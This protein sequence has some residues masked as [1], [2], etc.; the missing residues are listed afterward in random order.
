MCHLGIN[1]IID[2]SGKLLYIETKQFNEN[3]ITPSSPDGNTI[4]N[5][6]KF[7][8]RRLMV[9]SILTIFC[10]N[11]FIDNIQRILHMPH[12]ALQSSECFNATG[13]SEEKQR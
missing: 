11:V 6:Q 5:K 3:Y 9:P 1:K 2:I 10:I 12:A 7:R 8:P 13:Y 4:A